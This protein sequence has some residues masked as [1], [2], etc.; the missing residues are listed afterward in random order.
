MNQF[1]NFEEYEEPVLYDQENDHFQEDVT[2]LQKWA[3]KVTGP[4][5]D[6][7]CGTGRATIPLAQEGYSLIGV[8]I[9]NGML[10]HAKRKTEN[11]NLS[12]EW[13]EQDCT[14]LQLGVKSPFIYM[15]GNSFQHF[16][17]NEAQDQLLQSVYKHLEKEGIF[18]FGTRF[19]SPDELLQPSTEEYWRSYKDETGK[20][21]DVYTISNYDTMQQVQH[22]ITIRRQK[23]DS[24]KTMD[25]KKTNIKL[26]YVFP[27]EMD[28]LLKGI[29]FE[30]VGV[31]KDWNE[32]PLTPNSHQMIYVCRKA[33]D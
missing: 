26:R 19:P 16:L 12:I 7:A 31:Y 5:I 25:E 8:D 10:T 20:T 6:L 14:K 17:T 15:V 13:I 30:I 9:H 23:A 21:V 2:F 27:Q 24:G 18:I 3:A 33:A 4:I 22:Y 28:R 29:G 32:T 1:D 11:T